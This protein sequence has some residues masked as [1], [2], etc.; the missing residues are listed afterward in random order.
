MRLIKPVPLSS[1]ADQIREL[2]VKQ[3]GEAKGALV[4]AGCVKRGV[5][6]VAELIAPV[7]ESNEKREAAEVL[8]PFRRNV[9]AQIRALKA[10]EAAEDMDHFAHGRL[11]A[12]E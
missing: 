1:T 5:L 3:T 10:T 6:V 2:L 9:E 11:E 8:A 4:C 12:L 7:V